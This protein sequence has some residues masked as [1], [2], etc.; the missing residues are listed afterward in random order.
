[1][2]CFMRLISVASNAI[3]TIDNEFFVS[4]H[5]DKH[6]IVLFVE[7]PY[8]FITAHMGFVNSLSIV[9]VAFDATKI[10]RTV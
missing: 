5:G 6:I 8:K 2:A 3:Q 4:L 9:L 7:K 10:P 1:M